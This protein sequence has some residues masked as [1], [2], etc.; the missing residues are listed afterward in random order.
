M[1]YAVDYI[2]S[3]E[4]NSSIH[5]LILMET[6]IVFSGLSCIWVSIS[7]DVVYLYVVYLKSP[8]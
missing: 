3:T 2:N 6:V 8:Y 1:R 7:A 4:Q 5:Y